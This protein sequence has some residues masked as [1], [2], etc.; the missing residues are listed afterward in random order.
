EAR[1]ARA[2]HGVRARLEQQFVAALRGVAERFR[3]QR[4]QL[5]GRQ[6]EST[7]AAG[8]VHSELGPQHDARAISHRRA[9]LA[10]TLVV[11]RRLVPRAVRVVPVVRPVLGV[12][13]AVLGVAVGA[14]VGGIHL[15]GGARGV[16]RGAVGGRGGGVLGALG[17]RPAAG[18]GQ[19]RGAGA[20]RCRGTHTSPEARDRHGGSSPP[21]SARPRA[22]AG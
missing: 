8:V 5:L 15:L 9:V 1:R 4:R 12:G 16:L 17:A 2:V 11:P 19:Q 22:A 7:V 13:G 6:G 10:R 3:E 20:E 14:L 18:Q 21:S